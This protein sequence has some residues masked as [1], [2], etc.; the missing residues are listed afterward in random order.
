MISRI[1]LSPRRSAVKR[2]AGYVS[3]EDNAYQFQIDAWQ[4][5]RQGRAQV[6]Q[7]VHS[8]TVCQRVSVI[9]ESDLMSASSLPSR[10]T[11][12]LRDE[13][14]GRD[15]DHADLG[16]DSIGVLSISAAHTHEAAVAAGIGIATSPVDRKSTRLNSSH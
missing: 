7:T 15:K 13:E 6:Q 9:P 2:I 16:I 3:S 1:T 5:A 4:P 10:V 12:M 14:G 11:S 8:S